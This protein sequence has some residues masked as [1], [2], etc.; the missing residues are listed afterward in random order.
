MIE[1]DS[2]EV[3]DGGECFRL[4]IEKGIY[5]CRTTIDYTIDRRKDTH[6][7]NPFECNSTLML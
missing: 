6:F 1:K 4:H 5:A 2:T 3:V 7:I